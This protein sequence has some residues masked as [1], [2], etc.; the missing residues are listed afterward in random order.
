L[1]P[2][3]QL[4]PFWHWVYYL[5]PFTW[6]IQSLLTNGVGGQPIVCA[7]KEYTKILAPIGQTCGEYLGPF[8]A[9]NGGY[10]L[11]MN[12]P[13]E[14]LF[15]PMSNTDQFLTRLNMSYSTRWRNAGFMFAYVA[16]N[17]S[18]VYFFTYVFQV[19]KGRILPSFK[20]GRKP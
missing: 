17:T 19:R 2:F 7:A 9:A 10:L 14:C 6:V 15:C 16:F 12:A 18:L 8:I 11:D 1:Q 13:S 5:S 4:I 20:F 3:S